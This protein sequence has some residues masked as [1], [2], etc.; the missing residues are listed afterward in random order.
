[1]ERNV[2]YGGNVDVIARI[3][4]IYEVSVSILYPKTIS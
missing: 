3:I 1:M 2:V 4:E